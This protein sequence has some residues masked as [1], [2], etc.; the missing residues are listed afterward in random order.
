MLSTTYHR[1]AIKQTI[2]SVLLMLLALTYDTV[3]DIILSGLH[4]LYELIESSAEELVQ[5]LFHTNHHESE[6][7]VIYGFFFIFL[8]ALYR[9]IR[10]LPRLSRRFK[11]NISR[12]W[13]RKKTRIARYW[14]TFSSFQKVKIVTFYSV[15]TSFLMTWLFFL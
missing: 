12:R 10:A 7:V 11:R 3:L 14:H 5:Y 2:A 1:I 9:F 15:C 4:I 8:Y 13:A 6:I